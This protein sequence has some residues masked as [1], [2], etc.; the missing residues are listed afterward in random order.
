M[1]NSLSF[2]RT[3]TQNKKPLSHFTLNKKGLSHFTANP[4][5]R[6]T[7]NKKGLSHFTLNKKGLSRITK[8][9]L[10]HPLISAYLPSVVF[11]TRFDTAMTPYL[12]PVH[13]VL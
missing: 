9:T 6:F 4:Q 3:F 2:S 11:A 10:H 7:L 13:T 5:S 1:L 8:I 12:V